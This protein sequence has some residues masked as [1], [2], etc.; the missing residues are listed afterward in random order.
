M[1]ANM[2]TNWWYFEE[3]G[4]A[5]DGSANADTLT[6]TSATQTSTHKQGS[7]A[8]NFTSGA[9]YSRAWANLSANFILKNSTTSF[10]VGCWFQLTTVG[11]N[12]HIFTLEDSTGTYSG[13][14]CFYRTATTDIA[15]GFNVGGSFY[16][17]VAPTTVTTGT[18][19]HICYVWDGNVIV[20][21]QDGVAGTP[22]TVGSTAPT[23]TENLAFYVGMWDLS[24]NPFIGIIDE[25]FIYRNVALSQQEINSIKTS[26]LEINVRPRDDHMK[27]LLVM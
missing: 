24:L 25:L 17:A 19:Y 8:A 13:I 10:T 12:R 2:P 21:Y 3:N 11:V 23:L 16:A 22:V 26:G 9:F 6:R 18:W 1:V 7:F 4:D 15:A 5:V 27:T 14:E 20:L